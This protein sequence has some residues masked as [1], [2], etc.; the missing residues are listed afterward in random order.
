LKCSLY[1]KLSQAFASAP[2]C[3][4]YSFKF[5]KSSN[6]DSRNEG[7]RTITQK[8]DNLLDIDKLGS[9][10]AYEFVFD[11]KYKIDRAKEFLDR[12]INE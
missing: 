7:S 11:A 12:L 8:P 4:F 6:S 2:E 5:S 10:K 1:S 3:K 9:E